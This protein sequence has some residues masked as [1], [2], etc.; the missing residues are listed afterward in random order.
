VPACHRHRAP[1]LRPR[2]FDED[3]GSKSNLL[4]SAERDANPLLR[5]IDAYKTLLAHL[6]KLKTD[7]EEL[8]SGKARNEQIQRTLDTLGALKLE[9]WSALGH[10][11]PALKLAEVRIVTLA[12]FGSQAE[13]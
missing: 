11:E 10:W 2:D 13:L 7:F 1:Q 3:G 8:Y 9:A 12:L 5:Q 4:I 6:D